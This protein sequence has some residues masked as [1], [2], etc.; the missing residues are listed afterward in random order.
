VEFLNLKPSFYSAHTKEVSNDERGRAWI[1]WGHSNF[2]N[3]NISNLAR[4]SSSL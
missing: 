4:V 3:W 2:D 1:F